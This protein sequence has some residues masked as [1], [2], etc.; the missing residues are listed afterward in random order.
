[1][2]TAPS[3]SAALMVLSHSVCQVAGFTSAARLNEAISAMNSAR[4]TVARIERLG[5]AVM[6]RVPFARRI[7]LSMV[8][9]KRELREDFPS[10]KVP[11]VGQDIGAKTLSK[12][13]P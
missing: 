8:G 12:P 11:A 6:G 3:S 2:L 4:R 5:F 9:S 13:M 10:K 7:D 1:M